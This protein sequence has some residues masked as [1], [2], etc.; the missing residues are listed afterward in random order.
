MLLLSD[1]SFNVRFTF[2]AITSP[3]RGTRNR[4]RKEKDGGA[5]RA[6]KRAHALTRAI[7]VGLQI[8]NRTINDLGRTHA[9]LY[10][11]YAHPP[12]LFHDT[13]RRDEPTPRRS[14]YLRLSSHLTEKID[15]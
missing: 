15:L 4:R 8:G 6:R 7:F 10:S 11:I 1:L 14:A 5:R 12:A 13:P 2:I 3:Y 9:C